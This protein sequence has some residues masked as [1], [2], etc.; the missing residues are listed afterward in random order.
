[1]YEEVFKSTKPF[2]RCLVSSTLQKY[3]ENKGKTIPFPQL[4][5]KTHDFGKNRAFL[6]KNK[7]PT[8]SAGENKKKSQN[9]NKKARKYPHFPAS[10]PPHFSRKTAVF[11]K[12]QGFLGKNRSVIGKNA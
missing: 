9:I 8:R 12:N 10:L 4:P 11:G 2:Q 1:M 5:R 6:G 3:C 7:K